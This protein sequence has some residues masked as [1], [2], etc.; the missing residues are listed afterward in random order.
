MSW[1]LGGI[2]GLVFVI[3]ITLEQILTQLREINSRMK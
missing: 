1:L 3:A 2:L